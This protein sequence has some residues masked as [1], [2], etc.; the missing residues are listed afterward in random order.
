MYVERN[1][2]NTKY[3]VYEQDIISRPVG[4]RV[5]SCKCINHM[6][7]ANCTHF[8]MEDASVAA[9]TYALDDHNSRREAKFSQ[10]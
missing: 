4:I 9:Q 3:L 10:L 7:Q 5:G 8:D 1:D 2:K 6:K